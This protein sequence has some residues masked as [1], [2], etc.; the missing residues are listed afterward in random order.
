MIFFSEAG[1]EAGIVEDIGGSAHIEIPP[2]SGTSLATS[3]IHPRE[4]KELDPCKL[5]DKRDPKH[6]SI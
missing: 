2:L 1:K 3:P 6:E 4:G 5:R